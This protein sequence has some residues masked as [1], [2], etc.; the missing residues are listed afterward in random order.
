[1]AMQLQLG[2]NGEMLPPQNAINNVWRFLA[3]DGSWRVTLSAEV[4]ALETQIAYVNRDD[5]LRRLTEVLDIFVGEFEPADCSRVG[6]RYL[7]VLDATDLNSVKGFVR[8]G[9]RSLS[10]TEIAEHITTSAHAITFDVPE[11]TLLTRW[12]V[13]PPN[14][15]HDLNVM[16]PSETRRWYL[17]LDC[18]SEAPLPFGGDRLLEQS[19]RMT[20]RIYSFFLW[21]MTPEFIEERKHA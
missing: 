3:Q 8:Q 6:I 12:G 4:I 10:D 18:F 5:F 15:V 21:A 11:G 13:L 2:P 14:M 17:Y 20:E 1:M 19:R 16:S 7:N 9:L